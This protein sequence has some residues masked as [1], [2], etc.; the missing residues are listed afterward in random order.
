MIGRPRIIV[1]IPR[2]NPY[3]KGTVEYKRFQV[4]E[5]ERKQ[6][7]MHPEKFR[8]KQHSYYECNKERLKE[9]ASDYRHKDILKTREKDKIR[10]GKRSEYIRA[11]NIAYRLANI[12]QLREYDRNRSK[13]PGRR[14][15]SLEYS[16]KRYADRK[17]EAVSF[18]GGK[19][20]ECGCD[21]ISVLEFHHIDRNTKVRNISE[22]LA[23]SK[24]NVYLG[25]SFEEELKNAYYYVKN[26]I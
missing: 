17:R 4:R 25:V 24:S 7:I 5:S 18:L 6:K 19:C 2:D 21:D 15:K 20:F 26:V 16:A 9:A 1:F 11:R 3:K 12:E 22:F 23:D 8:A 14:R 10:H 13:L